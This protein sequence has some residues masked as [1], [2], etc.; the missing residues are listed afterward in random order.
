MT[1]PEG[2][3]DAQLTLL[4]AISAFGDSTRPAFI[5]KL[6]TFEKTLLD[7]QKLRP[8]HDYLIRSAPKTFITELLFIN[9]LENVFLPRISKLRTK[10]THG[11]PSLLVLDGY[12]TQATVRVITLCPVHKSY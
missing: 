3:D 6:K 11:D 2:R 5:S 1:I 9:W 4:T 10:F 8:G 7:A 12:S